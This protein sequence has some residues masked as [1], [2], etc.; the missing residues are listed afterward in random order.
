VKLQA[1]YLQQAD[2]S[3]WYKVN[4]YLY[5]IK[6]HKILQPH[7]AKASEYVEEFKTQKRPAGMDEKTWD[8]TKVTENRVLSSLRRIIRKQHDKQ[9]NKLALVKTNY[10]FRLKPY[11]EKA[12][13]QLGKHEQT[14]LSFNDFVTGEQSGQ[15]IAFNNPLFKLAYKKKKDYE[16]HTKPFSEL[17]RVTSID[18]WLKRFTFISPKD[19]SACEF[20]DMQH[21]DLGIILQKKYGILN[22]Q[23]GCGKTAASYA[24]AKYRPMK[25]TF[26][27][28][29][30]LAINLTWVKFM[31]V[32]NERFVLIK[33]WKD[34]RKIKPGD[35]VLISLGLVVNLERHLKAYVKRSSYKVNLV[36]DESDEITNAASRRTKA[37]NSVFRKVRRKLLA[38]GTTTRN[39]ITELYS[40]MELL[41][42]NSYNMIC[43][44]ETIYFEEFI[45]EKDGFGDGEFAAGT[46]I[47][48]KT[49][50]YFMQPFPA[51]YGPMIFKGCFNPAKSS[52]FGIAKHN[53]DIFN[54]G[55]LLGLIA[56]AIITRK[57][58]EI[59]GDKYTI[60]TFK[61]Q[62]TMDERHVYKK[63]IRELSS[64]IPQF[65]K[66]TG[67][68]RKDRMLQIVQQLNLLIKATSMPQKFSFYHGAP[69]PSKAKAILNWIEEHNEKVA[70][71]ATSIEAV[72]WYHAIFQQHFPN[73]QVFMIVGENSFNSRK[74][75]IKEFEDTP[76]GILICTQQSLKS[77][78]NIPSCNEVAIESLQW[79]IPKME[80][81]YFRF[82]RYDSPEHT[83]VTFF[84][85]DGTIEMNL[86]A[87]LMAKEKLN[88]Y[89]KTLEYRDDSDIYDEFGIDMDILESILTKETDDDGKVSI[90]WGESK[91]A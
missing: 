49:N 77:S 1:E 68:S 6:T 48:E 42:N 73:R 30:S 58:R 10:G 51:R 86:L 27:I 44:C 40:Q 29:P 3:F 47:R 75:I 71:G 78:V 89:I 64:V 53:Q 82:I 5:E 52:V 11:S 84:N 39:N 13:R 4:K 41:Y 37:V 35:F 43:Y 45:K 18:A 14:H 32:N 2:G 87:L 21:N 46:K 20:N 90:S 8:K 50:K 59:A 36:F 7:Y 61:V 31:Q 24:W 81:F 72:E 33:T 34:F 67:N 80:Q 70:I 65:F 85:Y 9:V 17:E 60:N 55:H 26:I 62:Q 57:F 54:Q 15:L 28:G 79:N 25:N 16:L 66:S 76:N 19:L 74:N 23:Q 63:I 38:T 69:I 91:V 56:Q 12:K 22:W 88:D 83:N